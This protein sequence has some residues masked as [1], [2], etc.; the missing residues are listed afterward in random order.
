MIEKSIAVK[1]ACKTKVHEHTAP[2]LE[3]AMNGAMS[4]EETCICAFPFT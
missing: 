3:R 4:G 1:N 2:H